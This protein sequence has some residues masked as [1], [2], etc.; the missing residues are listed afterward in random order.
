MSP[1]H[2]KILEILEKATRDMTPPMIESLVKD[3]G[4][5]PFIVLISC[6]LSLRARDIATYPVCRKLFQRVRNPQELLAVPLQELEGLFY[7]LGFYRKKARQMH[8]ISKEL[9]DRF[10]GKVPSTEQ[11]LLSIKGVGRKTAALVLSEGFGIPALCVDTHVH[12]L[13]NR[14]GFVSTKTP[15]QTEEALKQYVPKEW[16]SKINR[17][18]VVWG[19]NICTPVA[20]FCKTKCAIKE[21]CPK[22]GVTRM[23]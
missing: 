11:E 3:F 18:F 17:L 20:P 14:I 2:Y 10:D 5:D 16:W 22:I 7:S 23:R 8:E 6:L 13:S 21:L 15:R 1:E 4:R 19:Q 9:I 12:R